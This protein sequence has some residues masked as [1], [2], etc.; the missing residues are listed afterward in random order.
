MEKD[1]SARVI[2]I[3]ALLVGVVGLSIGFA[4]FSSSLTISSSAEVS[5]DQSNFN[6]DFTSTSSGEIST[7][8]I[9]PT[10][11]PTT[12]TATS[13]AIDNSSDPTVT[14]LHATFTEPGQSVTYSFW[15]KNI[16]EYVA[17]LNSITIANAASSQTYKKCTAKGT[18]TQ[19]LVDSACSGISMTVEVGT[20]A[21]TSSSVATINNHSLAVNGYDPIVVTISYATGSAQADGDFDVAFGDITLSYSSVD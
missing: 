15:A 17:Y 18:T 9:V 11:S 13:G 2:A 19:S 4:A 8:A 1:R 5:P 12:L 7:S 16:G 20:E 10:K 21:A 3:V 14:G 6:V